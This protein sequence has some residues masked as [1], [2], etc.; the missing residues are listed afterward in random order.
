MKKFVSFFVI[1]ASFTLEVFCTTPATSSEDSSKQIDQATTKIV[2]DD[3][4][5]DVYVKCLLDKAPCSNEAEDVKSRCNL[6][7]VPF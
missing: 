2:Q 7:F 4:A 3:K 1:F 6:L 5:R